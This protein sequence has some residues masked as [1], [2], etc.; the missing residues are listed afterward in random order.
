[1][2]LTMRPLRQLAHELNVA[3]IVVHH[4]SKG[5]VASSLG[6]TAIAAD[7][8]AVATWTGSGQNDESGVPGA[9]E[10]GGGP[11]AGPGAR[12]EPLRAT[13]AI[14]GRDVPRVAILLEM[15]PDLRFRLAS[16][17]R[18]TTGAPSHGRILT[19]LA[20]GEWRTVAEMAAVTGMSPSTIR[21]MLPGLLADANSRLERQTPSRRADPY[22]YRVATEWA[23]DRAQPLPFRLIRED[24]EANA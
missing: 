9:R 13:L 16:L 23:S 4:A 20:D 21:N 2:T 8:D 22:R 12:E 7:C 18:R 11:A 14:R 19:M 24:D 1:M 15:G 3:I 17:V 6:S 10:A 5:A